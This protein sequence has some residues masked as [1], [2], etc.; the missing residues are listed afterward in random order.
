MRIAAVV[1]LALSLAGC[2]AIERLM[3]GTAEP[4]AA[5]AQGSE[6]AAY[7]ASLRGAS[8]SRLASEA[9]RQREAAAREPGDV[10]RVKAAIAL[11]LAPHADESEVL[12][13]V[14]PVA[15]RASA[16]AEVRGMASFLQVMAQERR[17]L[18]ESA[19]AA[20]THLREERH[21]REAERQRAD[22]LQERAA[23][24]QQ[25]LDALSD[26]EKSLSNR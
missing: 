15:A 1:A 21:G 25:K 3:P 6:L 23:Q 26:L 7:V 5:P 8:E 10:A 18:R 14:E 24:L 13:L 2:S 22:A 12:A 9:A 19:A 16:P 20:A 11:S 17:R 4:A